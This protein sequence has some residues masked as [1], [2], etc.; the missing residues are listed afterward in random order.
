MA[1]HPIRKGIRPSARPTEW[2]SAAIMLAGAF[3]AYTTD[4]N[5]AALLAV[6][7]ACVPALS[8]A[9]ASWWEQRHADTVAVTPA[10]E[11]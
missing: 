2:T 5:V 6:I 11:E 8:T 7:G 10:V 9:V 1:K 4:H 3:A